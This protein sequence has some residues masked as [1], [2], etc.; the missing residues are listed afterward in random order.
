MTL[1]A[2]FKTLLF[3]YTNQKDIVIGTPIAGRNRADIENLIGF[4]VNTQAIRT[5][6]SAEMSFS[7]LLAQVRNAVLEAH[8]RQDLPFEK[9]VEELQ[10]ERSLSHT[11]IFQVMFALQNVPLRALEFPGVE[12]TSLSATVQTA[13]FDFS[14]SLAEKDDALHGTLEYNTDLF[15]AATMT[16][17]L[18]HYRQ[19]LEDVVASEQ[20]ALGDL[21]MLTD[22]ER[23]QLLVEWNDT[24]TARSSSLCAHQQF[25][26]HAAT[27]PDTIAVICGEQSLS[28]GELS[29]R[30]NALAQQ[31]RRQGVGPE[32]I[33]GICTDRSLEM[34]IGVIGVLKAGAAYLPLDPHYPRE[35]LNYM[36]QDSGASFLLLP[37]SFADLTA[38]TDD[39]LTE[40][41][42]DN[43]AY[44]IYTSGST[45]RPKGVAV[46]HGA[47]LNLVSWHHD[48]FNVTASDR[49]TLLAGV[50]FD[51]SVWELWPYVSRGA[52]LDLPPDEV[53]SSPEAL[54]DW[55]TQ[56]EITIS[57]VPTPI[58]EPMLGLEWS[59]QT[60]LRT[61]LT[62]GDRLHAW[63]TPSLP[64]AVVNNYGPTENAVVTT[65]GLI[66]ATAF[67]TGTA[68]ALG[69][70]IDN[71]RVFLLDQ[72]GAPVPA[73][74]TGELYTGGESLARGYLHRP[75]L[76]AESFVPDAL[77]ETAGARLYRTGDLARYLPDGSIEFLGR[78]GNQVKL[79]GHRIELGEIETALRE[80]AGV[81]EA[82]VRCWNP[83]SGEQCLVAYVVHDDSSVVAGANEL[84]ASL[85]ERLPD[86]MV[87]AFFV[88]L[89]ELPLTENGKVDHNALPAPA[90]S[91]TE[92]D[93]V[94]PRTPTEELLANIWTD[95]LHLRSVAV[96]DN[97]FDL[98][99]HSLLATQV[100]SRIRETFK[101]E[102]PLRTVFESPTRVEL[103]QSIDAA[104]QVETGTALTPIERADRAGDLPL[105]F[106]QQRLWFID[107]LSGGNTVYNIQVAVRLVGALDE[108][109][110]ERALN[111]I[112][113]RHEVLR[114]SFTTRDGM[115]VQVVAPEFAIELPLTDLS[116]VR[117]EEREASI[118]QASVAEARHSFD[119]SQLALLRVSLLRFS[120]IEHAL[121][122]TMHHII[123]DGWSLGVITHE[124]AALYE[125][126]AKDQSA[127]LP[128]LT[129]Q[130]ADFAHWQREWL[131]GEVLDSQ[132]SYWKKQLG[133]LSTLDL[134]LDHPRP[135]VQSFRG[136]RRSFKV[137]LDLSE[138]LK[139][140]SRREDV[141]LYMLLL[142][143][144]KVLL[145]RYSKRDDVVVGTDI[146]N[147]NRSEIEPLIGFFANQLVLRTDLSGNPTFRELLSRVREVTLGAYAH[148]DMP[149]ERLVEEL[150]PQRDLSR[151]P[152]FQV[153]F[154]LQNNP[155]PS[156]EI[157]EL[158]LEPI[159]VSETTTAF[160][161]TLAL[162][163]SAQG[164]L[165][166]SVRYSTDLFDAATIERLIRHYQTL[167]GSIVVDVDSRLDALEMLTS[168]ER[169]QES[170]SK[171]ERREQQLKK[172]L[173]VRPKSVKL[174]DKTLVRESRLNAETRLPVIF[175]PA[176]EEVDLIG[177]AGQNR[178]LID[179]RLRQHGALLFRGFNTRSLETFE[180]FTTTIS[181]SLMSYGE[182]SSP[183]HA[184]SRH[185][186]TSTDHPADQ[187]I[188]LHNEQSYTLNW[189]M[190]IWFL[191]V[192]PAQSGG[193]TP[194]ADSRRIYNRLPASIVERFARQQVM[195]VRNY[196][197][198]L[199]L[200][201]QEA[202]QT[203]DKDVV[204]EH[205]R[206]D[207]I[208]FEWKDGNRLRT[209]QVRP[210][211]RQ[212]PRT[213]ETVWFNHAVFFNVH[214]LERSARE[215]LRAG[216]DDWDLPF[217][218]FYGDGTPIEAEVVEEIYRV[219][220]E[221]QVA[222]VWQAGDI[223]MLDNMLCAH[224]REPFVAPREIA[225]AMA[226]PYC[227]VPESQ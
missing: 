68:P 187:H 96:H 34:M 35:R 223:L 168:E 122:L 140:I 107:K 166:G 177:W 190:K 1:L 197:D 156:L 79:R 227:S 19:L 28:Y 157:G 164:E 221:E 87:P 66:N 45:G 5:R 95:V 27:A 65:S 14:L 113:R 30:A 52:S 133:Q 213:R 93:A 21:E 147:R 80:T 127:T 49:S 109:A 219:Y 85:R 115:P 89:D 37:E 71:V 3:R 158:A 44:V 222:F 15:D 201:W 130:Y 185:I 86:Y 94:T 2:A 182:R 189:P 160:D 121:L 155:M 9:L 46:S 180:Q 31:L 146:A 6:L 69:K 128:E 137:P 195:Y 63:P 4:F 203:A 145:S 26:Q 135:P 17:L 83:N 165:S 193:R 139:S 88:T 75:E 22:D 208:E 104:M 16:R 38:T 209:K 225:V 124:L 151:N 159:E 39:P 70:P 102:L 36:M 217:N 81:R 101:V 131:R 207:A 134:P 144:F 196:G 72:R 199:G 23:Q 153:M 141:T 172:L 149:F 176:Y 132:L 82:V 11:P 178:E 60:K 40:V 13:K 218:T 41:E 211:V 186:Y 12:V 73:G 183:R 202:F 191:C 42:L 154:I 54:R 32:H 61:L 171:E 152:L 119:L 224:G 136:A 194:I 205:C 215:S 114:T 206:R 210:A 123:A 62:G 98:G 51:A 173:N 148:Q 110:L 7:D 92:T 108:V 161:I 170:E 143:A 163:Q 100:V 59:Q 53:R 184:L 179:N 77:S 99:G 55:L 198:G 106:A 118:R 43:L 20:T 116:H 138:A 74:V 33:V 226:E 103:A 29:G 57:F 204:A 24:D 220:L 18:E 78:I 129:V 25:A 97:F 10:P 120:A 125:A 64:F 192:R 50:S 181:S 150:Q 48:T 90:T 212:H 126:Y 8:A 169:Q 200:S 91:E 175:E 56:H 216:V 105:S 117:E 112:V 174:S 76:T 167:L 162:T 67:T 142:A 188:L 111:K 47:L 58:A 84:R 214:S